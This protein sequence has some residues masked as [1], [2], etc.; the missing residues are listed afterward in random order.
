MRLSQKTLRPVIITSG[1]GW[2][3]REVCPCGMRPTGQ[4]P[5]CDKSNKSD[6]WHTVR[7]GRLI[8]SFLH[9][10][11]STSVVTSKINCRE[12]AI[13]TKAL[14]KTDWQWPWANQIG[15]RQRGH[16]EGLLHRLLVRSWMGGCCVN[17]FFFNGAQMV[18]NGSS[19]YAALF[20]GRLV[21]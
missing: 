3:C 9:A 19:R 4:C 1:N 8:A 12:G 5:Q 16:S 21:F 11:V 2:C 17:V 13:S 7:A 18:L 15:K 14:T 6:V 10:V 20:R